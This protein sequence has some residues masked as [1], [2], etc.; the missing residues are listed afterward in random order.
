MSIELNHRHLILFIIAF[1]L[2]C[3]AA[4]PVDV[5]DVDAAQYFGISRDL[6]ESDNWLQIKDRGHD[7]LDKPPLLFWVSALSFKIFGVSNWAYKLPSFLFAL[8]AVFS[9]IRLGGLLYDRKTGLLA[10]LML[11]SCLGVFIITNDIRTD[12]ILLGSVS[13]AVWQL[14]MFL[15]TK[16]W[17]NLVAGF[18]GVAAAMLTKGPLGLIIPALALSSEFAY[19]R[20]WINFV[21]WQWLVGLA[22]VALLLTPMCIGLYQQFDLHPEKVVN[23]STGVSGLKFYFWTQSFGRITGESDW[24]TKFDN[25]AGPFFFTH[26]F[27]WAFFPWALLV[28]GALVKTTLKLIRSHLKPGYIPELLSYGG[29]VLVFLAMS[30]SKYKLPHYIYITFPFAALMAARFFVHDVFLPRKRILLYAS[31]GLHIIFY[32]GLAAIVV[33]LLFYSF[34]DAGWLTVAIALLW[35]VAGVAMVWKLRESGTRL[36]YP[37][38]CALLAGYFT[39]NVHFYPHLLQFQTTSQ[40][41]KQIA[42]MGITQDRYFYFHNL[43][44]F[45]GDAYSGFAVNYIYENQFDSVLAAQKTIWIYTDEEGVNELKRAGY[46]VLKEQKLIDF[47]VQFL[48]VQFFIPEERSKVTRTRFLLELGKRE[49]PIQ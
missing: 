29:F 35:L 12:T 33:L 14:L 37:L 1:V 41:G 4:L 42:S 3:A 47:P 6:L 49:A 43:F 7:Y 28:L 36:L 45:P 38:L 17:L 22:I 10:G 5:M 13:F 16:R 2:V 34:P 9:T 48:K 8:L 40:A 24:G 44:Q 27:L 25:G 19:K 20:Q 11:A 30:A 18:V 32:L 39:A 46:A 31:I 26:T 21:R 23:G 15:K